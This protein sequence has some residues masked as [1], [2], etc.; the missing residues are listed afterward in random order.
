MYRATSLP[1]FGSDKCLDVINH[2][3]K[4]L[5]SHTGINAYPKTIMHDAV[6]NMESISHNSIV[7]VQNVLFKSRVLQEITSKEVTSLN[8]VILQVLRQ[9]C[10]SIAGIW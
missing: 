1:L 9:L 7:F 4:S 3:L 5:L 8:L 2:V 6:S 10:T